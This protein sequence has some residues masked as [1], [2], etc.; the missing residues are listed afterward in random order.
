MKKSIT[1]IAL[2]LILSIACLAGCAQT[3]S[4][5]SETVAQLASGGVLDGVL[6]TGL[7]VILAAV[8]LHR[9]LGYSFW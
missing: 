1:A 3:V 4:T 6:R 5:E 9:F 8:V 2:A 7:W